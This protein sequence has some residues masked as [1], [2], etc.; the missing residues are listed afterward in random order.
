MV[1]TFTK[2]GL[3]ASGARIAVVFS[4]LFFGACTKAPDSASGTTPTGSTPASSAAAPGELKIFT[5]SEYFDE[6]FLRKFGEAHN[7]KVK[8]DYFSSN[9][10]MLAKLKITGDG[11]G[12]DLIL[13]SDYMVRTLV[14][15]KMIQA[16][17]HSKL[18]VLNDF[19]KDAMN[20]DYDPGLHYAVPLAIGTT[21]IAVDENVAPKVPATLTWKA[22]MEDPAYKGKITLLDD[23]KEVLQMALAIQGKSMAKATEADVK[24]AFAYL[25]AHKAQIK[26]FPPETRPVIEADECALCQ[27]YSGDVLSVGKDHK[28]IRFVVPQDGATIWADNLAIPNNAKNVDIAY[29]FINELLGAEGAKSFTTRTN[30]RTANVKAKAALP[31]EVSGNPVIFPNAAE[32]SRMHYIVPRKDLALVIDKEW[33]LLKSQ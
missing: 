20:P 9:E 2:I 33:A 10:E 25:K 14:E 22:M 5:W 6:D 16:L 26:G 13:P 1:R 17:D 30:Y 23:S 29:T 11:A 21:G 27:A 7:V 15:M 18:P 31:K 8:A 28:G 24:A 19:D 3:R 12:Y 4:L 32:R